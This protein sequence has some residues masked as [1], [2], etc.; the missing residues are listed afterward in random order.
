MMVVTGWRRWLWI[1]GPGALVVALAVGWASTRNLLF[2]LSDVTVRTEDP[3]LRTTIQRKLM[4]Y[5]GKS[6][7]GLSLADIE[8]SLRTLPTVKSLSLMRRWPSEL[9][10]A[11]ETKRPVAISFRGR[12]LWTLSSDGTFIDV[13]TRP[14]ALP[15]LK[16]LP[17]DPATIA[18]LF[19][20]LN[21]VRGV[22][23]RSLDFGAV[24][25][26]IWTSERGLTLRS[27]AA[28]L[29]IELGFHDFAA[30]WSRADRALSVLHARGVAANH[31][32]ATYRHRVV[33]RGRPPLRNF[34]NGLNSKELV[35][36]MQT[37]TDA[38]DAR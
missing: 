17:Q 19:Q 32:D 3:E 23:T 11:V 29:E 8:V 31:L 5:L 12:K 10:I 36:R 34:Q 33:V 7:F 25:E 2:R 9:V 16:S 21:D 28:D 15:L 14:L 24:D 38:V 27:Y 30:A 22:D 20:W 35:R 6:L 26:V 13:L 37:T 1:A 18:E 4:P